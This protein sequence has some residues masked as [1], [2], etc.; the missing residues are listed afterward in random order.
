[1]A[2][3]SECGREFTPS[4]LSADRCDACA[5]RWNPATKRSSADEHAGQGTLLTPAA[6]EDMDA[7]KSANVPAG[8][9]DQ[10]RSRRR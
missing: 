6:D 9:D 2:N 8:L 5:K 10:P 3:C 4:R 1:M 7:H